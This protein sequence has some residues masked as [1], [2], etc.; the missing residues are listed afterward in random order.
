[1]KIYFVLFI[2]TL[3]FISTSSCSVKKRNYRN[4]YYVSWK[5]SKHKAEP[6]PSKNTEKPLEVAPALASTGNTLT[7]ISKRTIID[8]TEE[9]GD[10]LF[11]K[12]GTCTRVKVY[13][14]TATEIRYKRCANLAGPF[15][16]VYTSSV[17]KI[18]YANGTESSFKDVQFKDIKE[19]VASEKAESAPSL[20]RPVKGLGV[21]A[22][23]VSILS[24]LLFAVTFI[25]A[26]YS[27]GI[28]LLV[29]SLLLALTGLI[30]GITGWINAR[31][32]Q[33]KRGLLP[34]QFGV[35]LSS[36]VLG[37]FLFFLVLLL[38]FWL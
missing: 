32:S 37:I 22:L 27:S 23:V 17:L 35:I 8:F 18:K 11:F 38:L 5:H 2:A 20:S 9:C 6:L 10:S 12:S 26:F 25:L 3:I 33:Y 30:L 14:I 31:K 29:F 7:S 34:A 28:F 19:K 4:G 36:L 13:E 1:M 16:T 15:I 21:A 24:F